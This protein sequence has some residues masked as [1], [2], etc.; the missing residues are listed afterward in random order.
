M[1]EFPGL[2]YNRVLTHFFLDCLTE[3]HAV[4]VIN[5]ITAVLEPGGIWLVSEFSIPPDGWRDCA[6]Q[7]AVRR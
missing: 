3:T 4:D 2:Q 1:R 5:R 7:R 6:I